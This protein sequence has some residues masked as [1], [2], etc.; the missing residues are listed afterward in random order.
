M[1][2]FEMFLNPTGH[3]QYYEFNFSLEAAWNVYHFTGYRFPQPPTPTQDFEI[4]S[5][6]W[7][8][9]QLSVVLKNKSPFQKFDVGLT[10]V[11]KNKKNQI[12]YFALKH[13]SGKPDFHLAGGFTLQRG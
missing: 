5:L 10:A 1:T 11:I 8:S 2:C 4:E 6:S 12:T 9:K 3:K 7:K 13:E